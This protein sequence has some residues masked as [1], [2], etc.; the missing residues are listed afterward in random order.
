VE[1]LDYDLNKFSIKALVVTLLA[2]LILRSLKHYTKLLD[3]A[4]RS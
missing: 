3:E 1:W 4:D 2:V